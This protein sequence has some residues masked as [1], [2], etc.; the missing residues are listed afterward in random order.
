M[1]Q[2]S[3]ESCTDETCKWKDYAETMENAFIAVM[4]EKK[5]YKRVN[6]DLKIELEKYRYQL[7]EIH[8]KKV[9]IESDE[10]I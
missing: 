6:K 8:R 5:E 2:M 3:Y 7:H 9:K 1:G 4:N 10:E